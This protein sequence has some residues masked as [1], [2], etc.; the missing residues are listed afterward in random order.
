MTHACTDTH[1]QRPSPGS[2]CS[3]K[4]M[5]LSNQTHSSTDLKISGMPPTDLPSS[6]PISSF[7]VTA[8]VLSL[9]PHQQHLL[10]ATP[11]PRVVCFLFALA[12]SHLSRG[13]HP[14]TGSPP[15]PHIPDS[16]SHTTMTGH[17]TA[18]LCSICKK[19][20]RGLFSSLQ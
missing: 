14:A 17:A 9:L 18:L 8:H 16:K 10:E 11:P 6:S 15:P 13:P 7:A 20:F 19:K 3:I 12:S 4:Q 2:S 1:V 5:H